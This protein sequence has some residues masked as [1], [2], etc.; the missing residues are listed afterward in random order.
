MASKCLESRM[1]VS[2]RTI[3]SL[4]RGTL[5]KKPLSACAVDAEAGA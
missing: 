5:L 4:E 3:D 1:A 2:R